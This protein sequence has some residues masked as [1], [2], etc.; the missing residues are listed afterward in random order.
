MQLRTFPDRPELPLMA[1]AL[2]DQWRAIGV[3]LDVSVANYSEIPAG[4]Q[5]GSL[6]VALIARNCGLTP[7]PIGTVLNDFGAGGG[8]W[9][10]MNWDIPKVAE[11]LETIAASADEAVRKPL[12]AEATAAIH[13]DLPLM[14]IT[15]YMHTVS[16]AQGFDGVVIDLRQRTY[17]LERIS[18]AE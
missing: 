16:I 2:Q 9:G 10:A 11:A 5:A 7:D 4:H 12:I 18:W 14:P 13:N 1:A 8:D 3:E 6:E 15:W 17:G